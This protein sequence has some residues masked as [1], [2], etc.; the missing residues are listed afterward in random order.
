MME[1][2]LS[3]LKPNT[4][5]DGHIGD[6]VARFEKAG[7]KITAMRMMHLSCREAEAFYAE[8]RGKPF[9][10]GLVNFMTRGAIVAMALEGEN[11]IERNRE[12]MGATDP[13]KAEPGTIRALY[14]RSMTENA[15]H[16]SD[17]LASASREIAFFFPA[18]VLI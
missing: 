4:V 1:R 18:M 13:S 2:T 9:F 3:I 6:V 7:L 11:A 15:V 5:E 12:I 8:H 10:E 14:A 17:S 16:G